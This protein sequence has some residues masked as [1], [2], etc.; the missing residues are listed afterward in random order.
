[1]ITLALFPE[2]RLT[3]IGRQ[4]SEHGGER[5]K[6]LCGWSAATGRTEQTVRAD[7]VSRCGVD[8]KVRSSETVTSSDDSRVRRSLSLDRN[9]IIIC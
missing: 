7:D 2:Q 3:V 5:G 4:E 1:M 8:N 9:V 6:A